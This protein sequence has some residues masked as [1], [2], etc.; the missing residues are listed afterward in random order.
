VRLFQFPRKL[1]RHG[2]PARRIGM[3]VV[4]SLGLLNN[5]RAQST[6]PTS[7]ISDT[8]VSST[9]ICATPATFVDARVNNSARGGVQIL[10]TPAGY[11]VPPTLLQSSEAA[12][13]TRTVDCD[14]ATYVLLSSALSVN[15]SAQELTL[16]VRPQ[17]SLLPGNDIDLSPT[18]RSIE[19]PTLALSALSFGVQAALNRS[20]DPV[21]VDAAQAALIDRVAHTARLSTGYQA[22]NVQVRAEIAESGNS[23]SL[24][25]QA[26]AMATYDFS[27]TFNLGAV[28]YGVRSLDGQYTLSDSQISGLTLRLGSTSA[29]RLP[30]L[31]VNLLLDADVDV[32]VGQMLVRSFRA[33]AGVLT[34]RNIP[35]TASSG[36][37]TIRAQ[38]A[39]Q[40]LEQEFPYTPADVVLSDHSAAL[41]A[42][43]GVRAS[44]AALQATGLYGLSDNLTL[45]GTVDAST[46]VQK[47]EFSVRYNAEDLNLGGGL[48]Y[49]ST[50]E[51][52][53]SVQADATYNLPH[54][55]V[56]ASVRL[57]VSNLERTLLTGRVTYRQRLFEVGLTLTAVP[58]LG[59]YASLLSATLRPDSDW[60]L[61]AQLGYQSATVGQPQSVHAA[62]TARWTPNDRTILLAE[63]GVLRSDTAPQTYG[64]TVLGSY[65]VFPGQTVIA[66][67]S[68]SDGGPSASLGY[69]YARNWLGSVSVSTTGAAQASADVSATLVAGRFYISRDEPGPGVLIHTGLP[70]LPLVVGGRSVLT[71]GSGDALVFLAGTSPQISVR[72]DLDLIPITVGVREEQRDLSLA[73][74]GVVVL[75]WRDNFEQRQYVHLL[76]SDGQPTKYAS[77]TVAGQDYVTDDVG[78]ALI[79]KLTGPVSVTLSADQE[80]QNPQRQCQL[81]L[82]PTVE[83]Q[84]CPAN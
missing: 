30:R 15:Y 35:L 60:T 24:S 49:D 67:V 7:Q 14:G 16:E 48:H 68:T 3:A 53:F 5:A 4:L 55:G 13:G 77:F 62:L 39:G 81:D 25:L 40:R 28:F 1:F 10:I 44:G 22:G 20:P 76:W 41:E 19:A 43:A 83:T 75:D 36:S 63:A 26:N 17:L 59:S 18:A 9:E 12:Y 84:R 45:A 31:N 61:G 72:P 27:D 11:W 58:N 6:A 29:Y 73:R 79:R 51:S 52:I 78:Y 37:V 82:I 80:D 42:R 47:G 32:L 74:H 57:P 50:A 56:G 23:S 8:Q 46:S 69:N 54:W 71:D 65:E 33:R 2:S 66:G 64:A 21:G 38:T 70:N 34:L